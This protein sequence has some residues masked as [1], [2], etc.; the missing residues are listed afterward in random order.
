MAFILAQ[1]VTRHIRSNACNF[2]AT[3]NSSVFWSCSQCLFTTDSQAECYFHE[4]LHTAPTTDISGKKPVQKYSC[5]LCPKFFRK[6]SLRQHL[7]QHTFE[8]PYICSTCGANFTRQSSLSNHNKLEHSEVR[9][10]KLNVEESLQAVL[11]WI[12]GKCD[13]KFSS[14]LE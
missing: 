5:P 12:C 6:A 9:I 8:R 2:E 4:I 14:R 3:P 7:R 11:E 1:E 10:P 13:E